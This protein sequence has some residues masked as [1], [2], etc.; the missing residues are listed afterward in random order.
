MLTKK[1][2]RTFCSFFTLEI[3]IGMRKTI[4][5]ERKY[6]RKIEAYMKRG[7]LLK[8]MNLLIITLTTKNPSTTHSK[9]ATPAHRF[10]NSSGLLLSPVSIV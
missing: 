9:N 7:V 3:S 10:E 1:V 5:A 4:E 2:G 6:P 8:E